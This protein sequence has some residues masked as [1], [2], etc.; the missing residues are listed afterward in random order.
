MQNPDDRGVGGGPCGRHDTIAAI[1]KGTVRS[2]LQE[3]SINQGKAFGTVTYSSC[4][5]E[6]RA[7]RSLTGKMVL[8]KRNVVINRLQR[9]STR[10]AL[11]FP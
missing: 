8:G 6:L 5:P 3:A 2:M 9:V 4:W 11:R 10:Q 1:F 7:Q